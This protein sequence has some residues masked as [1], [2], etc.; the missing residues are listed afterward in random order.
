MRISRYRH[1][2]SLISNKHLSVY[3]HYAHNKKDQSLDDR[4]KSM[5]TQSALVHKLLLFKGSKHESYTISL[6]LKSKYC[7]KLKLHDIKS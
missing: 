2:A 4:K 7:H 6:S 3:S 1:R 5:Y